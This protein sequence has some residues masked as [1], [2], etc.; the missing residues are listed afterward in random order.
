VPKSKAKAEV[1]TL[2]D[3][4]WLRPSLGT[5]YCPNC[6]HVQQDQGMG[7]TCSKCGYSPLPSVA[8]PK[9]SVFRLGSF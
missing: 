9:D 6:E 8:Y 1:E 4:T 2:S 5:T 7:C 3:P